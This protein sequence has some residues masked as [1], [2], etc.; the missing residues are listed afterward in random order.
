[1]CV[2]KERQS[3]AIR[4]APPS[5]FINR[6][7]IL[8]IYKS[9]TYEGWMDWKKRVESALE[10]DVKEYHHLLSLLNEVSDDASINQQFAFGE[11]SRYVSR[12]KDV[13]SRLKSIARYPRLITTP[14]ERDRL[15][16]ASIPLHANRQIPGVTNPE[17]VPAP[18]AP[19]K[20]DRYADFDSYRER[21]SPEL[22]KEGDN[23]LTW[24]TNRR[25]LHDL[26]KNQERLGVAKEEISRTLA[27]LGKQNAEIENYYD[28]VEDSLSGNSDEKDAARA[29]RPSGAY[30]KEEIEKIAAYDPVLSALCRE[31]R[32]E[33]NKKYI[34][35]SDLK[36]PKNKE[37]LLL[38]IRE[39]KE[40]N[41]DVAQ[42]EE[43]TCN[44][45]AS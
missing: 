10:T 32:I 22:Q 19:A 42:K 5:F 39:L 23:L 27:L 7:L 38:R 12:L 40:W 36:N 9:M 20:W 28:R 18:P 25:R 2:D 43:E 8:M 26:A 15:Y 6:K 37:E 30:T 3:V 13:L 1:M 29:T 31:K 14:Q 35:R 44:G 33:A 16:L 41:I 45:K 4:C 34:G 17:P 24:F 21:L 11:P